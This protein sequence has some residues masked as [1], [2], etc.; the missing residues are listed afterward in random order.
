MLEIILLGIDEVIWYVGRVALWLSK[1][2]SFKVV[3]F[4]G[5][6]ISILFV[7]FKIIKSA[8]WGR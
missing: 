2:N 6:A 8:I 1:A 4:L 5:V 3:F 7:V